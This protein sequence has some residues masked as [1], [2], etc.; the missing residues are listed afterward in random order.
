MNYAMIY[1]IIYVFNTIYRSPSLDNNT[2]SDLN[3]II[4][5]D[6]SLQDQTLI[7]GDMNMNNIY[8][9]RVNNEYLYYI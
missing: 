3:D 6:K 4:N 7:I 1:I 9:E 8:N 5:I 2:F